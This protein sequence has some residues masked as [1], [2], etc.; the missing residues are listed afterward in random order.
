MNNKNKKEL[1]LSGFQREI[2]IGLIL[3]DGHLETQNN[4]RTFRLKVEHSI[5]QKDYTDW[6]YEQF[7]DF[8]ESG[9]YTKEKNNKI[10]VGFRTVSTG[11]LRFYA[12][13]FY[14]NGIKMVPDKFDKFLSKTSLAIWYLDDGSR[15]SLNHNTYNIHSL[16]YTMEDLK[17]LQHALEK[18][19]S[20]KTTLHK[21]KITHWRIYIP[22]ESTD[23]FTEIILPYIKMFN[24]MRHKIGNIE[25]KK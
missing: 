5:T 24:S 25:P 3:G 1:S 12:K 15:K 22:S 18:N 9:V 2:L 13:Q 19:F 11:L 7:K 21:Q 20:I 16:G 8:C 23:K 10:Y 6:L 17:K 14:G 4:G